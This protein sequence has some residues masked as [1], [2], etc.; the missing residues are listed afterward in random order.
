MCFDV[1]FR[2][3]LMDIWTKTG[4]YIPILD[5]ATEG[6]I[7]NGEASD[8]ILSHYYQQSIRDLRLEE[9]SSV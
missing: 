9:P 6:E 5:L 4:E 3:K 2:S 7:T 8:I 1:P